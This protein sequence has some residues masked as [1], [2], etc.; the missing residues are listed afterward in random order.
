LE[1]LNVLVERLTGK[2]EPGAEAAA[3][4]LAEAGQESMTRLEPLLRSENE[5][6]R[7]WAIRTLAAMDDPD[8][9]WFRGA[10]Q[11]PSAEVRA[12][13]ALALVAHPHSA[14][15]SDL[16]EA[17]GDEDSVTASLATRALVVAGASAVPALLEAFG[18]ATPRA[19]IQIV[20][21]LAE[22]RDVRAIRLLLQASDEGSAAV[23]YWA[24]EGL[25]ML[26]LDMIYLTPE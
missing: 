26:G 18:P 1:D 15:L 25:N 20:R 17:L 7:W 22:L 6:H 16:I 10:L 21:A 12:A 23:Q 4:R 9:G 19:R 2:D 11:D 24:R 13:G 14:A 3:L 8:P 5:D